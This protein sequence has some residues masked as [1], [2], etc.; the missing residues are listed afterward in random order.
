M[1]SIVVAV[2]LQGCTLTDTT[3]IMIVITTLSV[4]VKEFMQNATVKINPLVYVFFHRICSNFFR[5]GDVAKDQMETS[6]I[7]VV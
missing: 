1:A 4:D 5:A 3:I 2:G 6:R 7:N